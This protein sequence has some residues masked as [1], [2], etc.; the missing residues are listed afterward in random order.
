MTNETTG[1]AAFPTFEMNRRPEVPQLEP[2]DDGMT[3]LD[4]FAAKA[5]PII[6]N[7]GDYAPYN[8]MED[9]MPAKDV[10]EQAYKLA[11]AMISERKK[12]IQQ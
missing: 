6:A 4:F 11:A 3:I 8:V 7:A 1:G 5:M 12:Y 9:A 2:K 10:A